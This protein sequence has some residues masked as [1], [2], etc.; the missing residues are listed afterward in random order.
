MRRDVRQR[1][2][3]TLDRMLHSLDAHSANLV[4]RRSPDH[5]RETPFQRAQGKVPVAR[6][7]FNRHPIASLAMDVSNGSRNVRV[8]VDIGRR[9]FP[10]DDLQ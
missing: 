3:G 7:I 10:L 5:L 6:H 9:R 1:K 4:S 2:A 8:L